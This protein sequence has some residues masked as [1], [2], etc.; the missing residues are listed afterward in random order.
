MMFLRVLPVAIILVG[1]S[2][3]DD[4][5]GVVTSHNPTDLYGNNIT[6]DTLPSFCSAAC[7]S[8]DF[9]TSEYYTNY[10]SN[11]N[12]LG[13]INA[14][15]A[16][17]ALANEGKNWGGNDVNVAVVD[18]GVLSSHTDLNANYSGL[19]E[20]HSGEDDN[21]HGTHVAGIIAA[22]KNDSIMHGV[23]PYASIVSIASTQISG[24]TNGTSDWAAA[25]IS[26]G[27]TVVNN[28][29]GTGTT[30]YTDV[31]NDVV[32]V[33]S[34]NSKRVVVFSA[35][36]SGTDDPDY[37]ARDAYNAS[38]NGQ[39]LAVIS[40]DSSN[41][42]SD[43]GGGSSSSQCGVTQNYCIAAPGDYILSTYNSGS[44]AYSGG[45]SMAAPVVS[46]AA[47][48]LQSAWPSLSGADVVS[49]LLNTAT[50]LGTAGVDSE[51]GY[52]LLNLYAAV[53]NQGISSVYLDNS[54]EAYLYDN[55]NIYVPQSMGAVVNNAELQNLLSQGVFFDAYGR[56]YSD[57]YNNKVIEYGA[58]DMF[59]HFFENHFIETQNVGFSNINNFTLN[60][61]RS[62]NHES[63]RV[64]LSPEEK[65]NFSINELS[66]NFSVGENKFNIGKTSKM[67]FTDNRFSNL[68]LVTRHSYFSSYDQISNYDI[69]N[70]NSD[71]EIT[72]N[73]S[74][75]NKLIY[76]ENEYTDT[77]L[78]GLINR[79][80]HSFHDINLNYEFSFYKEDNSFNGVSGGGAFNIADYSNSNSFGISL[81]S[82]FAGKWNY[83]ISSK[84]EKVTPKYN[85][86]LISG[87]GEFDSGS[88][89]LGVV[90]DKNKQNKMGLSISKP[91][92]IENGSLSFT[93]P[94]GQDE[95]GVVKTE[96]VTVDLSSYDEYDI[97]L[98]WHKKLK[99]NE[100]IKFNLVQRIYDTNLDSNEV[101]DTTEIYVQYSKNF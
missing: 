12:F 1:C 65:E 56:D 31:F 96:S 86:S 76:G 81:V 2:F 55:T 74:F 35:G 84:W 57:D 51:F 73:I 13:Q 72:K 18:T 43:W 66:Y 58:G 20:S 68:N 7:T 38:M 15:S 100:Q 54:G 16:Y 46:G 64:F 47:A 34:D 28:S 17:A 90:Y 97:E 14:S 82:D 22:E 30:S 29:W 53:Q 33:I 19:S 69:L 85:S 39:M 101:N 94:T 98:F 71:F 89:V 5:S 48:I 6:E 87:D 88:H 36:N 62:I 45:T 99:A 32:S 80:S 10:G 23:S 67:S 41:V 44:Y 42:R 95:N 4:D 92:G 21:G 78:K 25:V 52:G 83:F 93:I 9:E 70:F 27:A 3:S 26:S 60:V 11:Q 75:Q 61:S 49:I 79:I 24:V 8:T 37:P 59:F 50:D 91:W 40:V 77:S 63:S